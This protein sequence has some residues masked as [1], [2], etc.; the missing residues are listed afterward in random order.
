MCVL[1][2]LHNNINGELLQFEIKPLESSNLYHFYE[3]IVFIII[4][5]SPLMIVLDTT[6][7]QLFHV[8]TKSMPSIVYESKRIADK[9]G[10]DTDIHIHMCLD[11]GLV[12]TITGSLKYF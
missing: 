3:S 5:P 2:Q 7:S 11:W 1:S 12:V 4:Q 6:R 10:L 9:N 8:Q